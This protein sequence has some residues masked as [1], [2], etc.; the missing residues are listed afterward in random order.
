MPSGTPCRYAQ[1]GIPYRRGFLL[2]GPPGT[3]KTSLVSA[4]NMHE[5]MTCEGFGASPH[6]TTTLLPCPGATPATAA[7]GLRAAVQHSVNTTMESDCS[8]L[9]GRVRC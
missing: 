7:A 9:V 3:G 2:H 1:H 4:L 5:C 6:F 8:D